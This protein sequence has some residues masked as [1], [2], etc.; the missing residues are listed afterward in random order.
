M[1]INHNKYS[2]SLHLWGRNNNVLDHNW[3]IFNCEGQNRGN[4]DGNMMYE[5]GLD[6]VELGE[7]FLV[8]TWPFYS[9]FGRDSESG[10]QC[11]METTLTTLCSMEI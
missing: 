6:H 2:T 8:F 10:V 1:G 3:W 7:Y 9:S 4:N 5:Y 11:T